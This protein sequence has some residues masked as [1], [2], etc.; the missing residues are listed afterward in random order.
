MIKTFPAN[1]YKYK[2]S[3]KI[4][5]FVLVYFNEIFPIRVSFSIL[6]NRQDL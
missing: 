3:I 4:I 6:I 5:G 1:R 2:L